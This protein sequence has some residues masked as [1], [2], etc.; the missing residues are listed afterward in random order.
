MWI[1]WRNSSSC[2][3]STKIKFSDS[4]RKRKIY[5]W[6][7]SHT[8]KL[9]LDLVQLPVNHSIHKILLLYAVGTQNYYRRNLWYK[10]QILM[11]VNSCDDFILWILKK[12]VRAATVLYNIRQQEILLKYACSTWYRTLLQPYRSKNYKSLMYHTIATYQNKN[13][14]KWPSVFVLFC[15]LSFFWISRNSARKVLNFSRKKSKRKVTPNNVLGFH[16]FSVLF[17]SNYIYEC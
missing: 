11:Y 1:L 4:W 6:C 8:K 12:D 7:Q 17:S 3:L 14:I 13:S 2:S 16:V 10:I 5:I 9:T 15:L